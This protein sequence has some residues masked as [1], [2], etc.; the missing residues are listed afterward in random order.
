MLQDIRYGLRLLAASPGFTAVALVSLALGIGANTAIF[1]LVN[2][3]LLK[4]MPVHEPERLVAVFTRDTRNP[5]RMPLSYPNFRDLRDRTRTFAGMAV[6]AATEVNWSHGGGVEQIRAQVVSSGYFPLLGVRPI[7]GW[8]FLPGDDE[9]AAAVA[10]VSHEFWTDRLGADPSAVGRTLIV[11]RLPFT[12]VGIAPRGFRGTSLGDGPGIWVPLSMRAAVQPNLAAWYDE[13]RALFLGAFGRLAPDASLDDASRDVQRIFADLVREFPDANGDRSADVEPL[14]DAR[15][16]PLRPVGE[17]RLPVQKASALAML[18]VGLVLI[19]ACANLANLLLARSAHR[20]REIAIRVALG[21]GRMRLIRQMLT[22][23]AV[24]AVLGAAFGLALAWW[25]L[26]LLADSGLP[27]PLPVHEG[28]A[29]DGRVLAL[30]ATLAMLTGLL[31]GLAPALRASRT[32]AAPTRGPDSLPGGA[33]ATVPAGPSYRQGLVV[34]QL[35][36]SLIALVAA[37]I[38]VRSLY[39]AERIDTGFDTRVVVASFNLGREGYTPASGQQFYRQ[40]I[41]RLASQPGVHRVAI[42]Q[43]PPLAS[44]PLRSIT[45]EGME[46]TA[47]QRILVRATAVSEAYFDTLGIPLLRGRSFTAQDGGHAPQVAI[48]NETLAARFWPGEDALGKRF[49]L[50]GDEGFTTIVGIA[51]DAKYTTVREDPAP[52]LYRPLA[53]A[54]SAA[55]TVHVRT[56]TGAIASG[57]RGELQRL[58]PDL[59]VFDVR[60]LGEQLDHSLAPLRAVVLLLTALGGLALVLAAIGLYGVASCTVAQRTREIGLRMALGARRT[61]VLRLV[62]GQALP[63]VGGGLGLGLGVVLFVTSAEPG[64]LGDL[65][66]GSTALDPAIFALTSALLGAVALTAVSIPAWRAAR[67]DPLAAL[68]NE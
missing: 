35:A 61:A 34:T 20:R 8:G 47:R 52:H 59:A 39:E 3:L 63:L 28:L 12:I 18:A 6:V 40:A 38:F 49:R 64:L 16:D 30:T 19:L 48:A 4:P 10:V 65:L 51:R 22:E 57:I 67:M 66:P 33:R 11:N 27:L 13:R 50:F 24:L 23:S 46:T 7:A 44:G 2:A 68:R 36:V 14:L 60:T 31:F 32:G 17:H 5:G 15:L 42:A 41:E 26:G 58:D 25:T 54:Y 37:G 43:T 9:R 53:Q 56:R 62:I 1:S 45:P 21:A 55:A 29:L